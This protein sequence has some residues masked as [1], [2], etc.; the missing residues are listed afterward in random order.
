MIVGLMSRMMG[1]AVDTFTVGFEEE[2]Y[3]EVPYAR[4][5]SKYFAT[6]H[7]EILVNTCSPELLEKLV[8]HLDEPVADPAAVPTFLVS[9][10]ARKR[11]T[12][13]LTGEGGDELFAGYDYHRMEQWARRYRVLPSNLN[14]KTIPTFAKMANSLLGRQHYHE[15]TIWY[16]SLPPEAR[17]MA[18]IAI[19]TDAQ[20]DMLYRPSFKHLPPENKAAQVFAHFYERCE[21]KDELHRLMYIDAKVWLP[22][23]LLMKVDKMSMANS[24]EARTPYLDHH[25]V[26]YVATIPSRLKLDRSVSK[27]I[28]KEVAKEIVPPEIIQRP[29]HTFDV[30]IGKWLKGSLRDLTLDLITHDMVAGEHWFDEKH[31]LGEMWRGLEEDKPGYAHQFWSLV[32][33]GL[34]V[35]KYGVQLG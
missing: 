11:V 7:H 16:W 25:L 30:P 13:V 29:K 14:R 21:T 9:E 31:I 20:K 1:Q 8:W 26:D 6:N 18:W 17:M 23:D 12:V 33:L 27:L 22:D 34:W 5:T 2:A 3:N 15:R 10:L 35:R 28:L 19:F 32:I 4:I 24:L